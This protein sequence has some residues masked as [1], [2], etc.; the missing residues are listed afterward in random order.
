MKRDLISKP[1]IAVTFYSSRWSILL[2]ANLQ[3]NFHIC[4]IEMFSLRCD[5]GSSHVWKPKIDL[6]QNMMYISSLSDR[7]QPQTGQRAPAIDRPLPR[8]GWKS[9]ICFCFPYSVIQEI[10]LRFVLTDSLAQA[11]AVLFSRLHRNI[12]TISINQRPSSIRVAI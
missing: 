1:R 8:T 4:Y 11:V 7:I 3:W 2:S 9:C 12:L 10:K 5:S 6:Q